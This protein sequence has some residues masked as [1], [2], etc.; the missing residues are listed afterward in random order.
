MMDFNGRN[1]LQLHWYLQAVILTYLISSTAASLGDRTIAYRNCRQQCSDINCTDVAL[2]EFYD[3]QPLHLKVLGWSCSEECS[4][5]CMW[6]TVNLYLSINRS[7]PQ[8][9]GKW[10]F[11][12]VLGV[13]EPASTLFSILNG[14]M[15]I[16]GIRE[17]KRHLP[18]SAPM[19]WVWHAFAAVGVNTWFWSTVFHTRDI[20][21]TE[22]M[23]YFSAAS[24]LLMNIYVVVVRSTAYGDGTCKRH[25]SVPVAALLTSL[26]I[27]HISYLTFVKFDYGYNIAVSVIAGFVN[28]VWTV[29]WAFT[30]WNIHGGIKKALA[31]TISVNLFL[32]LEVLDFAPI[33]WTFDAHSLWHACTIIPTL[34]WYSYIIED[35]LYLY[36]IQ[37]RF[38]KTE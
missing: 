30:N 10:P 29:V 11:I 28:S 33:W 9:H 19:Y 6:K 27:C 12:R 36:K 18:P 38:T 8:F 15:H 5:G 22:R 25:I 3:Q 20:L 23:D 34:W 16:I 7:V 32:A 2:D 17:Y 21:L 26:F 35:S 1:G 37:H 14:L 4:H 24:L 31:V 13:Q